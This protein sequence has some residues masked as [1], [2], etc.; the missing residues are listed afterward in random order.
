MEIWDYCGTTPAGERCAQL[1]SD[2]YNRQAKAEAY[3]LMRQIERMV[4]SELPAA[5][6]WKLVK[7]PHD[8]GTYYT[9]ALVIGSEGYFSKEELAEGESYAAKVA[10]LDNSG[11]IEEWDD[12]ARAE[13]RKAGAL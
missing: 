5:L 7:N 1:G 6:E 4:G 11:A 2:D 3:A 8:F 10:K 9:I 12:I 13:L